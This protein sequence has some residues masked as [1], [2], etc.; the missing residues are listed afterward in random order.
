MNIDI[1]SEPVAAVGAGSGSS[2]FDDYAPWAGMQE[3][4]IVSNAVGPKQGE[5][6]FSRSSN[7]DVVVHI[8]D[9]WYKIVDDASGKSGTTT[10]LT[11]RRPGGTSTPALADTSV[12]TIPAPAMFR[13]P[14]CL[15]W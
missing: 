1:T 4:N 15:R 5:N 6:G 11:S 7:G 2:P 8:P 10:S 12:A 9:F 3:Y 14:E 13:A